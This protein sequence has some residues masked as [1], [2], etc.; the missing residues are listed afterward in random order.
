MQI[1]TCADIWGHHL[2][3][4][5]DLC[6][7]VNGIIFTIC[8]LCFLQSFLLVA[9]LLF[10][11]S[12][13]FFFFFW[14]ITSPRQFWSWFTHENGGLA[15]VPPLPRAGAES[16]GNRAERVGTVFNISSLLPS[17]T[18]SAEGWLQV[19]PDAGFM[20][21][22]CSVVPAWL[23]PSASP[24]QDCMPQAPWSQRDREILPR[25]KPT[26]TPR[27]LDF[28]SRA[29]GYSLLP[30]ITLSLSFL[31]SQFGMARTELL[32]FF[33]EWPWHTFVLLSIVKP[34]LLTKN[35]WFDKIRHSYLDVTRRKR[36]QKWVFVLF[37]FI[38]KQPFFEKLK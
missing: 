15:V 31:P 6:L 27:G 23:L 30:R 38:K 13:F 35:N 16:Q 19:L 24:Q 32:V 22:S 20:V 18:R 36:D 5:Q 2:G 33:F 37:R 14:P 26:M 7:L 17:V 25:Q 8:S 11:I 21:T 34:V 10:H 12:F 3:L 4:L 9:L 1:P 29:W 28:R